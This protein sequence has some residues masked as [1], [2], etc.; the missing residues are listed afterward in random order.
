MEA[1]REMTFEEEYEILK[2]ESKQLFDNEHGG[3]EPPFANCV[4]RRSLRCIQKLKN[5]RRMTG[6]KYQMECMKFASPTSTATTDNLLIQGMM[7]MNGE[8]GEAID[9]V[10]KAMFHGHELDKEHL[11]K[12]L[13]DVMWY[14]ATAAMAIGYD[15]DDIMQMNIDKL[16]ARYGEKFDTDKSLHRAEGDI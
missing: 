3:Y 1:V 10:K 9:I 4:V 14:V 7:G 16:T 11:A 2:K 15:L 12:E 5:E 13:G 6:N 8:A